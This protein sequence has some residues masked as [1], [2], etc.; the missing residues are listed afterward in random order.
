MAKL[1]TKLEITTG[2]G[3]NYLCEM[4]DNYDEVYRTLAKVS[5]TD[6]MKGL[7]DL[8]KR[9]TS[10][11]KGSKIIVIKNNSPVGVEMNFRINEFGNVSVPSG[12]KDTFQE[13]IFVRQYLAGGEYMLLPNQ[14]MLAYDTLSESAAFSSTVDNQTGAAHDATLAVD[15]LADTDNVTVTSNIIGSASNTRLYL[16]PY[17]SATNCTANLFFCW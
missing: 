3:D 4:Q 14:F 8:A 7:A 15:S 2:L 5:G 11:L 6:A 10:I 12:G 17:T 9:N 13:E 16:E 1:D